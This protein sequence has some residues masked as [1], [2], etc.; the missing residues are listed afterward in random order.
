MKYDPNVLSN[1]ATKLDVVRNT[2]EKVI[3]FF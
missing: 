3:R 1:L 2:L